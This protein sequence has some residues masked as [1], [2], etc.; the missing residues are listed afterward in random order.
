MSKSTIL[1]IEKFLTDIYNHHAYLMKMINDS[2][3]L[4][5]TETLKSFLLCLFLFE[6]SYSS[7]FW[8]TTFNLIHLTNF[9]TE[10]LWKYFVRC[11]IF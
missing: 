3:F 2:A 9:F 11:E 10:K 1:Q 4:I 8:N 5:F 6:S 7:S